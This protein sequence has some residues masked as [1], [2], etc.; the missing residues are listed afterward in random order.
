MCSPELNLL[1][2]AA[3][4]PKYSPNQKFVVILSEVRRQ[5]NEV[6]SLP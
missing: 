2:F 3:P 4:N 1:L 5:P 6:E